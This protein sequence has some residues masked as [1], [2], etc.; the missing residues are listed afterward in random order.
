MLA[1]KIPTQSGVDNSQYFFAQVF[2]WVCM[3]QLAHPALY[4][5]VADPEWFDVDPD[6]TFYID[7]DPDP[8]LLTK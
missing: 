3:A 6:P 4:C 8:K 5:I 7:S 1:S 2:Q